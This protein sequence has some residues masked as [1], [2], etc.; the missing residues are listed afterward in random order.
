MNTTDN[1][2][3]T[4]TTT[5]EIEV[6][7]LVQTHDGRIRGYVTSIVD[8]GTHV[9]YFLNTGMPIKFPAKREWIELV[10]KASN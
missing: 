2:T 1:A 10:E 8:Y 7:D 6:G 4:T 3:E 5:P 9:C